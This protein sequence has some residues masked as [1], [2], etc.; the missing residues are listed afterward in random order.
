M[1]LTFLVW[2]KKRFKNL[3]RILEKPKC[4]LCDYAFKDGDEGFANFRS[5]AVGRRR[6]T[7]NSGYYRCQRCYDLMWH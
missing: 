7:R 6:E 4:E 3:E 2:R 1:G 5:G